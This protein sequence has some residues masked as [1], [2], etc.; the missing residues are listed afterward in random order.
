MNCSNYG[1]GSGGCR[2]GG[3]PGPLPRGRPTPGTGAVRMD[4]L[5][6]D[7]PP[8]IE[9][10]PDDWLSDVR[11]RNCSATA[12]GVWIDFLAL[13]CKND[14]RGYLQLNGKPLSHDQLARMTGC[15]SEEVSRCLAELLNAGVASTSENDVVYSPELVERE[16]LRAIA[17][18]AGRLGG[19]N[20][21]L[22]TF[23][24]SSADPLNGHDPDPRPFKGSAKGSS[25]GSPKGQ[26]RVNG[27]D[28][29]LFFSSSETEEKKHTRGKGGVGGEGETGSKRRV[30]RK[31]DPDADPN[32][33]PGFVR[34]WGVYP[35]RVKKREAWVAWQ[36]L[37]PD[38]TLLG[39]I[40][41]AVEAHAK[42]DQWLSG[43][44]YIPH[45]ATWLNARQWTDEVA[46]VS[47]AQEGGE[48]ASDRAA[49]IARLQAER[50]QER[51]EREEAKAMAARGVRLADALIDPPPNGAHAEPDSEEDDDVP[52]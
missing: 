52:F 6:S 9:I 15:S 5:M 26:Q 25:K 37:D 48:S 29:D 13:M 41:A 39:V 38:E 34:F 2:V 8:I 3:F 44:R 10:R 19:G 12:R 43:M 27:L 50:E 21:A 22:R 17:S 33:D 28:H 46:P 51:R 23:K 7:K 40:V 47:A 16:R 49:R 24:G 35:R 14:R 20:P 42:T 32:A 18:R 30:R 36:K 4:G 45:P 31:V 11:L 1:P